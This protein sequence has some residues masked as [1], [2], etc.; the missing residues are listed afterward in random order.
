MS[1]AIRKG[2]GV[3]NASTKSYQDQ[4][5]PTSAY[6]SD[7]GEYIPIEQADWAK[8]QIIVL[9]MP[10]MFNNDTKRKQV[11]GSIAAIIR[12]AATQA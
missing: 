6:D 7:L 11:L 10:G 2:I 3:F 5:T 12:S 4:T 9:N 1:P 8:I